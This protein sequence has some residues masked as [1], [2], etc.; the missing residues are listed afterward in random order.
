MLDNADDPT[1]DYQ[2]YFPDGTLDV[3][4]LTSRN[5]ECQQYATIT[6]IALEGLSNEEAQELLLKAACVPQ[7]L[8]SIYKEDAKMV[9]ILPSP[10][11]WR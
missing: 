7:N 11:H 9:A 2:D 10:T 5:N 8:Y 4:M 3:V 1:V 6:S